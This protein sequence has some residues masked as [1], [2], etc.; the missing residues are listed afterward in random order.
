MEYA[1][2]MP[3]LQFTSASVYLQVCIIPKNDRT[4]VFFISA[5]ENFLCS[6]I[7]MVATHFQ[8]R[9]LLNVAQIL[10]L[11]LM[12][13]K[14]SRK[15]IWKTYFVKKIVELF[16]L[17]Y[18]LLAG[19]VDA[20]E[21]LTMTSKVWVQPVSFSIGPSQTIPDLVMSTVLWRKY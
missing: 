17:G 8:F 21:L 14:K 2:K 5:D 7:C 6:V 18:A 13:E 20:L 15:G 4:T 19:L 9:S 16:H 12:A 1:N 10:V 3:W 11:P